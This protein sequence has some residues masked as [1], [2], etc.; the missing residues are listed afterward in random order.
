MCGYGTIG[1]E[2]FYWLKHL[3]L[4]FLFWFVL[5]VRNFFNGDFLLVDMFIVFFIATKLLK[6]GFVVD[7]AFNDKVCQIK[8]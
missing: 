3:L 4:L 7:D 6:L 2:V 1:M 8:Y 5:W